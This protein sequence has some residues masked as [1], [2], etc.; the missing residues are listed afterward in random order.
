MII[1]RF[2]EKLLPLPGVP[3]KSPFGLYY[4]GTINNRN[5]QAGKE[6][7]HKWTKRPQTQERKEIIGILYDTD[8]LNLIIK[9][10]GVNPMNKNTRELTKHEITE[11]SKFQKRIGSTVYSV[12]VHFSNTSKETIEDKILKLIESEVK[13][14]A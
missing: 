12:S 7:R 13:K 3:K 14:I 5:E 8:E 6:L 4:K 2:A 10:E 11:P 1:S 9:T